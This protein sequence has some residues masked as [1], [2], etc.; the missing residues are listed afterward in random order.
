MSLLTDSTFPRCAVFV[1]THNFA[2]TS[3][4]GHSLH[5]NDNFG[6]VQFCA[7]SALHLF[8]YHCFSKPKVSST[9]LQVVELTFLRGFESLS[10]RHVF[11][12]LQRSAIRSQSIY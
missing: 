5:A 4:P 7:L 1:H 11:N 3:G 9:G 10:L 2:L 6:S 12:Q 8:A